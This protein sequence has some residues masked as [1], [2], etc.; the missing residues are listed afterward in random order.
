MEQIINRKERENVDSGTH[1]GNHV[2]VGLFFSIWDGKQG[3]ILWW[4]G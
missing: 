3:E 2:P 4:E 1:A